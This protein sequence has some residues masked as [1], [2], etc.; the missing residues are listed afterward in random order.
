MEGIEVKGAATNNLKRVSVTL[1]IGELTVVTGVSGSGKSSLVFDTLYAE[2]YRRYVESLSS[3]A[4]Q[5]LKALPKPELE[6]ILNL[7]P[8]IAVKQSRSGANNRSTVGTLSEVYDGL[9]ILFANLGESHCHLCSRPVA[10]YTNVTLAREL[11]RNGGRFVVGAPLAS[12][13][14]DNSKGTLSFLVEQGFS[15]L[16]DSSGKV[17]RLDAQEDCLRKSD[18]LVVDR[19]AAEPSKLDRIAAACDTGFRLGGGVVGVFD[20]KVL[21][22]YYSYPYCDACGTNLPKKNTSMFSFNHP[23]GACS[24]CNGFGLDSLVDWST[25]VPDH[26]SSIFARG[27]APLNFGRHEGYYDDFFK[28][29]K[30][31]GFDSKTPFDSYNRSDWAWFKHGDGKKFGGMQSYFDWLDSKK[32]KPHYR[33]HAARYRRYETCSACNGTRLRPEA[34]SVLVEGTSIDKLSDV[35]IVALASWFEKARKTVAGE[36]AAIRLRETFEDVSSRLS[37]LQQAGLGYLSLNRASSTLSGGE[38]QRL[39]MARCL[40]SSLTQ[41]LYCLDEPTC[42]LHPADIRSLIGILQALRDQGNTVVVVEHDKQVMSK[43]DY[44]VEVGPKAGHLGGEVIYSGRPPR[45]SREGSSKPVTSVPGRPLKKFIR[46]SKASCHNLKDVSIR[47]PTGALT[48]VCGVSGSG[49]SSLIRHGFFEA[50]QGQLSESHNPVVPSHVGEVGPSS[51]VRELSGV[52]LIGQ[53]PLGRNSRSTIATYLGVFDAIRELFAAEPRAKSL[54]LAKGSFSFNSPGGRCEVCAGMG[55]VRED[56]SFLGDVE[57]VCPAC[58]GRQFDSD[59]LSVRYRGYTLTQILAMTVEQSL[60]VFHDIRKIVRSLS[61]AVDIGL[62]YLTLGQ[63][64]SSFSGGEAQRLKLL[65]LLA[66]SRPATH[67]VLIFDEPTSGLSDFD[68]E[69]LLTQFVKLVDASNTVV[70]IEHHLSIIANADWIIE[71]GPGA[72]PDGGKVIFEG[73]VQDFLMCER[74]NTSRFLK[75]PKTSR[76]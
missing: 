49:K 27:V 4:R 66:R 63:R 52:D 65:T 5:Y 13:L 50:L 29:A 59:V 14:E 15:K 10:T 18:Y 8:V 24:Q 28:A 32:Y 62:G 64:L 40:G 11:I 54:G 74:S 76:K 70:V 51:V 25:V 3:Y 46:L 56:L 48:V 55:T 9:Q 42:G 26:T 43:A 33:I 60:E 36:P 19:L 45:K 38:L 71:M 37:Y 57:V 44:L 41:T 69:K 73:V 1:P 2:S 67:E 68:V 16:M 7:P 21:R 34:R 17:Q 6:D 39:Q 72:G 31:R 61:M 22:R 47:V 23:Y 20:G 75:G 12:W 30:K 58:F 53:S 35:S